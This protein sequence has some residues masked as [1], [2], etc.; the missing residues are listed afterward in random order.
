MNIFY[1]LTHMITTTYTFEHDSIF[2]PIGLQICISV[3]ATYVV[4]N[5]LP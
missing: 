2:C 5:V 3:C 1:V 4:P